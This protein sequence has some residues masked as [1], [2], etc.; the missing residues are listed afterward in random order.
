MT[1]KVNCITPDC[2]AMI[3]PQTAE[4]TGGL[5]MPCQREQQQQA[6]RAYIEANRQDI[7]P[8]AGLTDPV[9]IIKQR[10]VQRPFNKLIRYADYQGDITALYQQLTQ[11]QVEALI[12]HDIARHQAGDND[13]FDDLSLELAAFSQGDLSQLQH[14]LVQNHADAPAL[15]FRGA[16][17]AMT[18]I[19]LDRIE[20]YRTDRGELNNLLCALAWIGTAQ[21]VEQFAAWRAAPPAWA[22]LLYCPPW[23][24]AHE[25]GW[26][27][28]ANDQ[29]RN[30]YFDACYPLTL[31]ANRS[32]HYAFTTASTPCP[33][34]QHPLTTMLGVDLTA[35]ECRFLPFD[36]DVLALKNCQV[37]S[38][39]GGDGLFTRI[40]VEDAN[41]W[42]ATDTKMQEDDWELA[43]VSYFN[44]GQQR[45]AWFAAHEFLSAT[46]QSQLGGLPAWVQDT[47]Y[48]CCPQC[49]HTMTFVAQISRAETDEYGEGMHYLFVCSSCQLSTANYQQT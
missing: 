36:G 24:Y 47:D 2:D 16:E 44:L 23:Q 1:E 35:P 8:Y 32:G 29:R 18:Q 45:P 9:E 22:E 34:C 42:L 28:N 49:Q 12:A 4:R 17:P 40:G 11:P 6:E 37:C 43:P 33:Q 26:E 3:L 7:D 5:C 41:C 15:I 20:Q 30:L 48:P 46:T 10:H 27:L 21:V 13:Y 25:A 39:F 38:C 19:L 31:T 14:Y